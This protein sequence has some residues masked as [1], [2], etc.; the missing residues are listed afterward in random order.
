MC[1]EWVIL[2]WGVSLTA[3]FLA[4]GWS[5][6]KIRE[7][8]LGK[9]MWKARDWNKEIEVGLKKASKMEQEASEM[10]SGYLRGLNLTREEYLAGV[11]PAS[12]AAGKGR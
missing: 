1:S 2:S 9:P 6:H 4:G 3:S 7:M 8:A 10:Q 5:Y 12:K 11:T